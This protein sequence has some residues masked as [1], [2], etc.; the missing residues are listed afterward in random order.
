MKRFCTILVLGVLAISLKAQAAVSYNEVKAAYLNLDFTRGNT[1]LA[2][3]LDMKSSEAIRLLALRD[4]LHSLLWLSKPGVEGYITKSDYWHSKLEDD[5]RTD[6][7]A[8][9]ARTEISIYQ[10]VLA[11]QISDYKG[12]AT[13]LMKAYKTFTK[14]SPGMRQ[15]DIDKISGIM[16]VLFKQ[17]PDQ[18]YKFLKVAGIRPSL[19]SGYQGLEK[20][21]RESPKGSAD[22]TE[23]FLLMITALKEFSTDPGASWKFTRESRGEFENNWLARYQAAMGAL[24]AGQTLE[25][26]RMLELPAGAAAPFPTWNY[27][28]GRC[29]QFV[30]D[31]R[32]DQCFT[33]FLNTPGV[34]AYRHAA[35]LRL[36]WNYIL[37]NDARGA[38]KSFAQVKALPEAFTTFDKQALREASGVSLPE[39]NLLRIR[40]LYD[41][42][43]YMACLTAEPPRC[44]QG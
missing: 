28:L 43:S 21:Y 5:R 34:D 35:S 17:V 39:S 4:F 18:A 32:S 9:A 27:Q 41:G 31:P 8:I 44:D 1:I 15:G 14:T 12:S 38:E 10:A 20:Y 30:L 16:G 22:R 42:G 23:A 3:Q 7:M 40:I 19:L 11:S 13:S 36:G 2:A 33:R 6:P 24:K 25:S 26:I 29:Y 37:R